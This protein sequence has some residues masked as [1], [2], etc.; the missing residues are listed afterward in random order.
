MRVDDSGGDH[1]AAVELAQPFLAEVSARPIQLDPEAGPI[2]YA[3][4]PL[5]LGEVPHRVSFELEPKRTEHADTLA[6][7]VIEAFDD[8]VHG[9]Q[10]DTVHASGSRAARPRVRG[11]FHR[12][13]PRA[14]RSGTGAWGEWPRRGRR[15][16]RPRRA[17]RPRARAPTGARSGAGTRAP[18]HE[19]DE[20]LASRAPEHHQDAG[21][22]VAVAEEACALPMARRPRQASGGTHG[23]HAVQPRVGMTDSTTTGAEAY[24][25]GPHSARRW[26]PAD[27]YRSSSEAG[28]GG[29]RQQPSASR[30]SFTSSDRPASASAHAAR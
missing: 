5:R 1:V 23:P 30:H 14:G 16:A 2:R 9:E 7:K 18:R 13:R 25:P 17:C 29:D 26:T 21:E 3:V 11:R 12:A 27:S 6:M 15:S 19:R 28:V 10:A 22:R 24:D 8:L 20:G 4:D